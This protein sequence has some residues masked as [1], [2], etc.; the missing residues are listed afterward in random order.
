[1]EFLADF[2][3]RFAEQL[4]TPTLAF[5]IAGM[6]IAALNSQ[7][8]IP[9]AIYHFIVFMLLMR[10]GL[11]GGM[12]LR[13]ANPLEMLLPLA[14]ATLIGISIPILGSITL[15]RLPGVR[16]EDALATSG[17]FGAVSASTVVAAMLALDEEGIFYEAWIPALYPF[18]DI[19]ALVTAIVLA[20]LFIHKSK[21]GADGKVAIWPII[22]ECLQ[23][24]ALTALILGFVLG[25][26][27]R[28]EGVFAEFYDPLFRGFLSVLML[29]LGMDAYRRLRELLSVAHWYIAYSIIAPLVHGLMG[30]GLGY[31][32]HVVAGLS[33][34]GAIML[35]IIAASNSD[36]SG[37]PTLRGGIPSANPAAY[38]GSSTGVGTPVALAIGIPLFTTLGKAVFGL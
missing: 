16:K 20:N 7:L 15:A 1:M 5:L 8:Q 35:A 17:L 31:V 14:S 22:K 23:G 24:A 2:V 34:G 6:V 26:F 28:P 38:V 29:I 13:E 19:P 4:Q 21:H 30:F 12:T 37:P 36:V 33:P 25:I 32:A 27:S 9:N 3:V 11:A 18:M 10:I